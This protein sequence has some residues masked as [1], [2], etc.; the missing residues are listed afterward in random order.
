MKSQLRASIS[1]NSQNSGS[2]LKSR[3]RIR[4]IITAK[5]VI[6]IFIGCNL[7]FFSY[8]SFLPIIVSFIFFMAGL[9]ILRFSRLSGFFEYCIFTRV[10]AVGLVASGI[11]AFYRIY[12][13][14]SP[15]DEKD[16]F[17]LSSGASNILTLENLQAL[18]E[19]SLAIFLW[20]AVYI[21]FSDIGFPREQYLGIMVNVTAVSLS[22]VYALKM[23]QH[24]FGYDPYR[25]KRLILLFSCCG[26]FW[27][28]AGIHLRD[29][30]VLLAV[31][32]LAHIWLRFLV[33]P[34]FGFRLLGLIG[35]NI[36][37]GI[38]LGFLRTEFVYVPIA[39]TLAASVAIMISNKVNRNRFIIYAFIL[40][41][42]ILSGWLLMTFGNEIQR[43]LTHGFENYNTHSVETN[44]SNSLGVALIINQPLP[45]R[46]VLGFV[47]LFV[48]PIP[49]WSG[50]QLESAYHLFKSLNAIFF[51]F[52]IPMLIMTLRQLWKYN[53]QRTRSV[54]FLLFLSLG[55]TL[56]IAG[57][58]METR[59]FGAFLAPIFILALTP[60]F[61]KRVVWKTYKQLLLILL[62][63]VFFV[64]LLW[65]L[66]KLVL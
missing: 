62:S 6:L 24:V 66:L 19:G 17:E 47:Y 42:M 10:F 53:T 13:S 25:F 11:S 60:D 29:S 52:L 2:Y 9:G 23:T 43:S 21:F 16:F 63:G 8:I 1:I 45:I 49:F 37:A 22:S 30:V 65:L 35:S 41:G 20:R 33:K 64:H 61:R 18:S 36:L 44:A 57:T 32:A 26:L 56:A 46:L 4:N 31:T 15:G 40:I 3:K 27:L 39:M 7:N 14:S 59:H 38:F 51:Y 54:L 12:F 58:S 28:F 55:F 48:F 34:D 5:T 50:F